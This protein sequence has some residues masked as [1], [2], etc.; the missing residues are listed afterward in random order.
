MPRGTPFRV[1][2]D[3]QPAGEAEK[4]QPERNWGKPGGV[5]PGSQVENVFKGKKNQA[6][7][8]LLEV[9]QEEPGTIT[10]AMKC[11]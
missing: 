11:H 8:M 9:K 7:Q 4:D 3:E 10:A 1:W 5:C 6:R 2:G